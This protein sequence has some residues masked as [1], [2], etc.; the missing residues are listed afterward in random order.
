MG[1]DFWATMQVLELPSV[2]REARALFNAVRNVCSQRHAE[3]YV[4]GGYVRDSLLY[5]PNDDIDIVTVGSGI[6]LAEAVARE[7]K[8][9]RVVQFKRFGTAN[10]RYRGIEVEFVGARRESY[11]SDSRKPIVE[12]G[13][14]QED[15]GRRDFTINAL[16]VPLHEAKGSIIDLFQGIEDLENGLIRT[17]LAPEQ[18]FSDDPLR[19][20]RAIRFATQLNFTIHPETL[21]AISRCR[22]RLRIV[23]AERIIIEF[24][25]IL[26]SP[27]PSQGLLLLESTG[28]LQE[29]LPELCQLK[30]VEHV[31]GTGHKDN[32]YHTLQVVDNIAKTGADLY[33][34][35]AALLHDVGKASTKRFIPGQGWTFHSHEWVG[36]KQTAK[37]FARLRMPLNEQMRRVQKLVALHMR[38]IVLSE[39]QVTDS[40]VRRL[41]FEAGDD[42][43][44]L[45]TLCEADITSKNTK[46]AARYRQ[47]FELVREKM[48]NLEDRD[49]IRNFQPPVSG[50]IIMKSYALGPCREVGLIKSAIK[51]AILEGTI[52]NNPA[53]ALELMV[54]E[55]EK[56]GLTLQIPL[57]QLIEEHG[58]PP[59]QHPE[60]TQGD[61]VDTDERGMRDE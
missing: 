58:Q 8:V 61:G 5:R 7:L 11:S 60:A 30:G 18:T 12:E 34:R 47:N 44:S 2:T 38:P 22:E 41:L 56:L 13:S 25:K 50:E 17:P 24:N 43:E 57:E 33:L 19:M 26:L 37:I 14:L 52:A 21:E 31:E 49:R 6:A 15:L 40:A 35:W 27:Q 29:F 20:M 9:R 16:A 32:F 55:G 36:S 45:M 51:E 48:R 10:F 46:R 42:V 54:Q 23:S 39:D 28:L 59:T 4:V 53:Q 3:A 1:N